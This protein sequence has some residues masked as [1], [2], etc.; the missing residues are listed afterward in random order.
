MAFSG[1]ER[2]AAV[3]RAWRDGAYSH[4]WSDKPKFWDGSDIKS[5]GIVYHRPSEVRVEDICAKSPPTGEIEFFRYTKRYTKDA[6]KFFKQLFM[7]IICLVECD[8]IRDE[9]VMEFFNSKNN[10]SPFLD[11][12][13]LFFIPIR[14][15]RDLLLYGNCCLSNLPDSEFSSMIP[16]G[17]KGVMCRILEKL[18]T[19]LL[20]KEYCSNKSLMKEVERFR[21]AHERTMGIPWRSFYAEE[22]DAEF[23]N[24]TQVHI[25]IDFE[26]KVHVA[27]IMTTTIYTKISYEEKTGLRMKSFSLK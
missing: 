17:S 24:C 26:Q 1:F 10:S 12:S 8:T 23:Y 13:S 11:P 14:R 19:I 16:T 4:V 3:K 18:E 6:H 22:R 5:G 9:H 25:H 15:S 20:S 7:T 21:I 27:W 2:D